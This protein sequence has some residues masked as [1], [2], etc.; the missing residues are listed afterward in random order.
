MER[1][2]I[3]A[4]GLIAGICTT[5]SFVPQIIKI[6]RTKHVRDLSL[7]MYIILTTGVFLWLIYG[8]LI[9]EAPVILANSVTFVL[10][11]FVLVAKIAYRRKDQG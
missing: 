8:V 7:Y 1:I 2:H 11:L 6:I 4:I 9:R 3:S 5:I 10:C